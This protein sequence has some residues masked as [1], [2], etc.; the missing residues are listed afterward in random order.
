M[1][2]DRPNKWAI[3]RQGLA[4]GQRRTG[5]PL[6][7]FFPD[8]RH[9]PFIAGFTLVEL[10]VVLA[11]IA[12]LA[13]LLLP[14]LQASQAKAKR[15][16]CTSNLRQLG[17]ALN[18]YVDESGS[19]PLALQTNGLGNWQHALWP[20]ATDQVLYCPQLMHATEEFLQYFPTNQFVFP[21]YGYNATGAL[22]I[23][24]PPQ[25]PG[26]GGNFVWTG[27]GVGHY[28]PAAENWVR[29]PSQMIAVG[30]GRTLLPPPLV[31]T[32]LSPADPLYYIFPFIMQPQG[33]P[34]ADNKHA[35]G[36]NMLFCDAHVQYAKQS[37]WLDPGDANQCLWNHDNQSHPEFQ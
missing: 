20:S 6:A 11:V 4:F 25:N 37:V 21:H 10:L 30:D 15:I 35:N 19:Y 28:V 2:P 13:A 18:L 16:H 3:L 23:N 24:P 27:P 32:A 1:A 22:R 12:L 29:A 26:L 31:G 5:S 17:V 36:A 33:Y 8:W 7:R 34:G 14:A 9:R